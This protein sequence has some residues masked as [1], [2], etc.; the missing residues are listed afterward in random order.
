MR[1]PICLFHGLKILCLAW[2]AWLIGPACSADPASRGTIL[3]VGGLPPGAAL[4]RVLARLDDTPAEQTPELDVRGFGGSESYALTLRLPPGASGRPLLVALEV[5]DDSGCLIA[6]GSSLRDIRGYDPFSQDQ[7]EVQL[8]P[9]SPAECSSQRPLLRG[10]TPEVVT[11]TGTDVRGRRVPLTI[12]GWGFWPGSRVQVDGTDIVDLQWVSAAELSFPI[13]ERLGK[14]GSVPLTVSVPGA[15]PLTGTLLY[16]AGHIQFSISRYSVPDLQSPLVRD[17]TQDGYPDL[18][19]LSS[20]DYT[21]TLRVFVN[22]GRGGFSTTPITISIG[23]NAID[24]AIGDLNGDGFLDVAAAGSVPVPL[25]NKYRTYLYVYSGDGTGNFRNEIATELP[26]AD[27]V[28]VMAVGDL[29]SDRIADLALMTSSSGYPVTSQPRCHL[30]INDGAGA[31]TITDTPDCYY[32][33][34][35]IEKGRGRA[36]PSVLVAAITDYD[37]DG[38]PDLQYANSFPSVYSIVNNKLA[39]QKMYSLTDANVDG[40][41][42]LNVEGNVYLSKGHALAQSPVQSPLTTFTLIR[43]G[44]LNG[45]HLSDFRMF[46]GLILN[47]KE[48]IDAVTPTVA[49]DQ[50]EI[51][52]YCLV[53]MMPITGD[54]LFDADI[55][56]DGLGDLVVFN[57]CDAEIRV[58]LNTSE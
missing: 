38:V 44:D 43:A 54:I 19:V 2:L 57:K 55:D 28:A 9:L 31:F 20:F 49:A 51:K 23:P 42:D 26:I 7:R 47:T 1:L 39:T 18:I 37:E 32:F 35:P 48:P 58:Y 45:D 16:G 36:T 41:A 15:E 22:D 14:Y 50:F 25:A 17:V 21:N 24:F 13:P 30:L 10:T 11:T 8:A 4:L 56:R 40:N 5:L 6:V 34:S 27:E 29:N 3:T 46:S 12:K 33:L 53:G 52:P